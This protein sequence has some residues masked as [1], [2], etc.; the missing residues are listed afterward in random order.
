MGGGWATEGLM[1]RKMVGACTLF[2]RSPGVGKTPRS[3]CQLELHVCFSHK[4]TCLEM[5]PAL[6]TCPTHD[7]CVL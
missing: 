3:H 1:A 6:I 5:S 7:L 2:H 4:V